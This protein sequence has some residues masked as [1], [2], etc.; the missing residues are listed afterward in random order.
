MFH[1]DRY[2]GMDSCLIEG[3]G[4]FGTGITVCQLVLSELIKQTGLSNIYKG[5]VGYSRSD[6]YIICSPLPGR[7][8]FLAHFDGPGIA[9]VPEPASWA[10]LIAGFGLT[11]SAMRRRRAVAA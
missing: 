3:G 5:I 7:T 9:G 1:K 11:G 2:F 8:A 10:M 4:G 6:M